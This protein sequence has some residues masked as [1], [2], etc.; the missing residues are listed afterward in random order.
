[1]VS[2]RGRYNYSL[3]SEVKFQ[4]ELMFTYN[5]R[6]EHSKKL[7][8]ASKKQSQEAMAKGDLVCSQFTRVDDLEKSEDRSQGS[9]TPSCLIFPSM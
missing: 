5:A 1:M 8:E 3:K 7:L 9:D 6:L 2:Q 4:R